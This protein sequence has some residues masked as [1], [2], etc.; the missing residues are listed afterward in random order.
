MP[1]GKV[2]VVRD[3]DAY[4]GSSLSARQIYAVGSAGQVFW[5]ASLAANESGWRS[6]RGRQVL[7]A[8]ESLEMFATDVW[9]LTASGYL[10]DAP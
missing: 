7:Y 10:L 1:A 6:W 8:G 5:Q 4:L 3:M 9:D 2:L